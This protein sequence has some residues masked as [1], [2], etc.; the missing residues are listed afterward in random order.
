MQPGQ[1]PGYSREGRDKLSQTRIEATHEALLAFCKMQWNAVPDSLTCHPA[2]H[3]FFDYLYV[4]GGIN[5]TPPAELNRRLDVTGVITAVYPKA[6]ITEAS[7]SLLYEKMV[8]ACHLTGIDPAQVKRI[9][10]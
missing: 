1:Q 5:S 6:K 9:F 10:S 8:E 2:Y 7:V 3:E 4:Y